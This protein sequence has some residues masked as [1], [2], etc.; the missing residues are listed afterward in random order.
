MDERLFL[1]KVWK[2]FRLKDKAE[3]IR[4]SVLSTWKNVH[5]TAHLKILNIAH[6]Q[7]LR[8]QH[9]VKECMR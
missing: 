5:K 4:L 9:A 6:I 2:I 1:K 3:L 8:R 7:T